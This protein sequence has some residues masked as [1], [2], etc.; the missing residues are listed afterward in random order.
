MTAAE[1]SAPRQRLQIL[2]CDGPS[3]GVTHESEVL[4]ELLCARVAADPDLKGRVH[5]VDYMCFGRCSEGPNM[6]V[7]KLGP[8]ERPEAEPDATAFAAERGFYPGMDAAKCDRVLAGHA[9]TGV[10]VADLVDDY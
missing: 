2:V 4:K 5:V 8:S 9:R 3:C 10:A 7:R 6:F 1:T